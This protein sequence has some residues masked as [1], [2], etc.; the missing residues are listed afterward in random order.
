MPKETTER[1]PGGKA[2]VAKKIGLITLITFKWLFVIGLV[3]C[4]IGGGAALGYVASLVK[5]DPVRSKQAMLEKIQENAVTGFVYFN[6]DTVV[7]ELRT[8]EDRRLAELDEIP[9]V[10]RDAVIAIEDNHFY[11][12]HG[13][14]FKALM[15]AVKQ[16][17]LHEPV[18][19]GASTITQQ[20]ARRVFLTLDR[21]DDRKAKEILLAMRMERLMSK[22]QILLAYLNKMP[23]G[24]GSTGYNLYGIKAAA[25]GIFNI[26]DLN[27][28]NVA[29][30]AYLAGLLQQPSNFSCFNG[31]GEFVEEGFK[32][33]VKR[34][35]LVLQRMLEEHKINEQQYQEALQFDLRGSLAEPGQK[36]YNTYP[37]LM[38]EAER[39]AT[40][41]LMRQLY[42]N[43]DPKSAAYDEAAK[44]VHD[45][46]L[47][48]GY[49]VYTTIDKT[50][51]DAMQEIAKNNNNFGSA[52]PSGKMEQVGAIML[53]NKTS[54]ILGMIEG[55]DFFEEQLNHATQALRQP[56]STMKPI[57]AYVPALEMG[58][59]Q[60]GEV[61]DDVPIILKDGQKGFH[62]PN[63]WDFKFHGLVT[64]RTAL[65][66]SY[67]IPAIKLFVYDVGIEKAWDYAKKMGI[68]SITNEDYYAQTGVIGGLK[69]G[70]SV[71]DLTNAY[72]TIAN[73]GVFNEAY[74]IRK[75]TDANGK[76]IYE[77]EKKPAYV[78]SEQTS[79]LMTDMMRT[80]ITSGTGTQVK[81]QFKHYGKIPVVGKTGTTQ[82]D[83]DAWFVGYSPDVT[84]GVWIG[85]E[86]PKYTLSQAETKRP[87]TI[88]SRIMDAALDKKPELFPTKEFT[89]PDGIVEYTVSDVS[90]KLPSELTK[91][92]DHLVTDL[93]N[94]AY[95]PKEEDDA[96][97]KTFIVQ[98]K[99]VDYIPQPS[100]P[101]DM[102]RERVVVKREKSIGQILKE[103]DDAQQKL[104]EKDRR[105]LSFFVPQDA[106]LDAP[107]ETDPR[108]DDGKA[109]QAPANV[110]VSRA[111]DKIQIA[112]QGNAESDVVGYR[113]YRSVNHG[114][115]QRVDGKVVLSGQETQFSESVPQGG[116]NG[117]YVTAVDVAG[118]ESSPSRIVYSDGSSVDMSL[119]PP[120][121]M[122]MT[123][124]QP[125]NPPAGGATPPGEVPKQAPSAPSGLSVKA[126]GAA[127]ELSWKANPAAEKVK[128]YNVY[129][130]DKEKGAFKKIGSAPNATQFRYYTSGGEGYYKISAVNDAGE[131]KFSETVQ[132]RK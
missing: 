108:T 49:Q 81:S 112:F 72:A 106:E 87:M 24:N 83:A 123:P 28:L 42:P 98:Y 130:S 3:S 124:G 40:D 68:H 21:E 11:E 2:A 57:A 90:G 38:L 89:K 1:A 91:A 69:Y 46:M 82:E 4:F 12:H 70:V 52:D 36:A 114:P 73:K 119:L 104:P 43:L 78:F 50:I 35:Q 32:R 115:F 37:F 79:Y 10:V 55:R 85:Y 117:Y 95:I 41:V 64:A 76:V 9:Q 121:Q 105:P 20:L 23:F 66:Q 14:D 54:A 67:N 44:E 109:P 56:G 26:S 86:L 19:T 128:Q 93:F 51:Y 84:V 34:Q 110:T 63:N 75:I 15:R 18:Q 129:Y 101:P 77:Q 47:H 33:A 61:I 94:K 74:M 131:S 5:D 132:F 8:E 126:Q 92:T 16:K 6:D 29:Q 17:L 60:P 30:A 27:E 48:D 25:K 22:D 39:Q 58:K 111:G 113:L 59:I 103:V 127:I 53:D 97:V 102:V 100:T 122:N 45:K 31:K 65:N 13:V 71:K 88:W 99:G 118:K 62:I 80:V 116:V 96:L 7:G 107:T 120:F 125:G